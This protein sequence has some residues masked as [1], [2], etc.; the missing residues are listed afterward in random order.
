[1]ALAQGISQFTLHSRSLPWDHAAGMLIV[2]EAG[3][4]GAFLD[5]SIYDTRIID[6]PVLAAASATSWQTIRDVVDGS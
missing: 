5:G 2:S 3:G 4:R 6:R 1:M